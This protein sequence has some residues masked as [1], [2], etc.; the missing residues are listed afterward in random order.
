MFRHAIRYV[1]DIKPEAPIIV[2]GRRFTELEAK[3]NRVK[4]ERDA[5]EKTQSRVNNTI[6]G[7]FGIT[8]ALQLGISIG[9][10]KD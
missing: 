3:Y 4:A 1:F 5:L 2:A 9:A 6:F 8:W 7:C 10:L